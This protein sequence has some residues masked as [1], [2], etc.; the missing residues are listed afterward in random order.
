MSLSTDGIQPTM[1]LQPANNYG[2]GMGMWG[3]AGD[4]AGDGYSD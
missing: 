2:G 1:P 3:G 4:I